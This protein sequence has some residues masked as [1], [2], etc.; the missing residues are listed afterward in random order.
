MMKEETNELNGE[1]N[2]LLLCYGCQ[3]RVQKVSSGENFINLCD[4]C[5]DL[6]FCQRLSI[7][8]FHKKNKEKEELAEEQKQFLEQCCK[9]LKGKNDKIPKG[10]SFFWKAGK[11]NPFDETPEIA[12]LKE[13]YDKRVELRNKTIDEYFDN[14]YGRDYLV[15]D[16]KEM[17]QRIDNGDFDD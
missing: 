7:L 10:F 3:Q 5:K 16:L 4:F 8:E 14:K 13:I 12:I 11:D 15:C 1:Q 17:L 9:S 6:A 2:F